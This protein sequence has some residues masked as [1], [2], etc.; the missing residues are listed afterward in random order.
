[1]QFSDRSRYLAGHRCEWQ[2]LLN[3]HAFGQGLSRVAQVAPLATG[4]AIHSAL[5]AILKAWK[6]GQRTIPLPGYKY[7]DII[8]PAVSNYREI[9]TTRGLEGYATE[10][11]WDQVALAEALPL[12]YARVCEDWFKEE[13]EILHIE[14]EMPFKVND[15]LTWQTRSDFVTLVKTMGTHAVH[16]FKSASSWYPDNVDLWR[17]NLQQ[18]V[19]G[20]VAGKVMGVPVTHYYIHILV[21]GS[22]RSP[23]PIVKPWVQPENPPL[24]IEDMAWKYKYLDQHTGRN[25]YLSKSYQRTPIRD[26]IGDSPNAM[27]DYIFKKVPY[28]VLQESIV[29]IGPFGIDN[30]KVE[31]FLRGLPWHEQ[32]WTARMERVDDWLKVRASIKGNT[33]GWWAWPQR[34]FQ[35]MLDEQF[36]R[37]YE[38]FQFNSQ[39]AYYNLC[40]EKP[41][42]DNPLGN[43]DYELRT[44]HHTT[45]EI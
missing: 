41:G 40:H 19:N 18:M 16:D 11:A 31:K 43:G 2:R 15:S 32:R 14:E 4:I 45:E 25:R 44:P 9:V 36:P 39:C 33:G 1:M 5:E 27:N 38:C 10:E 7:G 42:W 37:T 35:N 20:Y 34:D 30:A 28:D 22:K 24:Q 12:A 29:V 23:S 17:D 8:G 13:F 3:Y 6:Q 21:K 26:I